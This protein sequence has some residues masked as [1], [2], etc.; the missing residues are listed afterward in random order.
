MALAE[1]SREGL[2]FRNLWYKIFGE[3]QV[4]ELLCDNQT[5]IKNAESEQHHKRS[6][7]I[8]LK[9][10]HIKDEVEKGEVKVSW[11]QS[12]DNVVDLMTEPV[13]KGVYERLTKI[14][15]NKD[16]SQ[17]GRVKEYRPGKLNSIN[18]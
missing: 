14:L 6:K 5:A 16:Y 18:T 11:I 10:H 7:H 9:Y 4:V 17:R 15:H 12:I 8:N 2:F 1:G 3:W 13:S